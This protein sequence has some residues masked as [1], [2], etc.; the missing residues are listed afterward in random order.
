MNALFFQTGRFQGATYYQSLTKRHCIIA[1]VSGRFYK[2][3]PIANTLTD[4]T[5]QPRNPTLE[6]CW[7]AQGE[8]FLFAQDNQSAPWIYWGAG[9][10]LSNPNLKELPV[11]GP[12]CSWGGRLWVARGRE[13]WGSNIVGGEGGSSVFFGKDSIINFTE[14]EWLNEGGSFSVP[15]LR[16]DITA[17]TALPN[18]NTQL[19]QADICVFVE[20]G[21][22]FFSVPF[23]R[24]TWKNLTYPAQRYGLDH[25]TLSGNS[26][27]P[28]NSDLWF[29]SDDGIRSI[30]VAIRD[31]S[32]PG[33]SPLSH[34]V[35]YWLNRDDETLLQFCSGGLF[36]NW[37]MFTCSP[38]RTIRGICHRG[39]VVLDIT[40]QTSLIRRKNPTWE[41]L[42]TGLEILQIVTGKFN[43]RNRCFLFVV[44][45]Q[46]QIE[47]WEFD[48]TTRFDEGMTKITMR[49]EGQ[50]LGF[51][52]AETFKKLQEG[53]LYIDELDGQTTFKM[54]YRPDRDPRWQ[55]WHTWSECATLSDCT[56]TNICT[57]P[58]PL[59]PQFRFSMPF[60]QPS[61][62]YDSVNERPFRTGYEF[63]PALELTGYA[64]VNLLRLYAEKL[65]DE[66]RKPCLG[67][68]PCKQLESCDFNP[69]T[70]N[71]QA[72]DV[73]FI[74][75]TY[76]MTAHTSDV[77]N[78][79]NSIPLEAVLTGGDNA[80]ADQIAIFT[81]LFPDYISTKRF[82]PVPGNHDFFTST[83]VPDML[84]SYLAYYTWINGKR[85]YTVTIGCVQFL[86]MNWVLNFEPDGVDCA[87]DQ[88]KWMNAAIAGNSAPWKIVVGHFPPYS[89]G[90]AHGST[91]ALQCDYAAAGID[92]ILSGHDHHYER[93]VDPHG[94]PWIVAGIGGS[95]LTGF[96]PTP[97]A[98][99]LVRF[100]DFYG[101][102]RIIADGK[103]LN[104]TALTTTATERDQLILTK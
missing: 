7:F 38:H 64:R 2:I 61:D 94:T 9:S 26:V 65:A 50:K 69:F 31:F 74:A 22:F 89:S 39:L 46:M 32:Q 5:I 41:G 103:T 83:G 86:M 81:A 91:T 47:V 58:K 4:I 100:D 43:G 36:N 60:P 28:V 84:A 40:P 101:A 29:R 44:N 53:E 19:G 90:I 56:P 1:S 59:A 67:A 77:A 72:T 73:W 51:G 42:W 37:L 8:Q 80:L 70:F 52:S 92:L 3:D 10:R 25:G 24:T 48:P 78:L 20:D 27:V 102:L 34:E 71:S 49:V 104:V 15:A 88:W 30:A 75:D 6:K 79:V 55:D 57:P 76:S 33:Q 18:L 93:G 13:F 97:I 16:G 98:G 11:G 62:A 87:G 35:S 85:Y 45:T 66:L 23:D 95:A 99:S 17:M 21:I 96:I 54:Q 63:Q 14:N 12:M 68:G 82:Y